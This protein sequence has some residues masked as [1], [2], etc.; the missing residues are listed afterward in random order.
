MYL[1]IA[2][3]E[4]AYVMYHDQSTAFKKREWEGWNRALQRWLD[5]EV[6]LEAWDHIGVD[7][8]EDYVKHVNALIKKTKAAQNKQ[9]GG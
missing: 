7:F 8:D 5:Q 9:Q 4:R 3:H 2:L 6:F 1:L